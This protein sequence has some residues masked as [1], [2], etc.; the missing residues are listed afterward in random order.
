MLTMSPSGTEQTNKPP[1][2]AG[3]LQ[4]IICPLVGACVADESV[5]ASAY[6]VAE[7]LS[8]APIKAVIARKAYSFASIRSAAAAASM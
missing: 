5:V 6:A 1:C 3:P 7:K 4:E 8:A 2:F